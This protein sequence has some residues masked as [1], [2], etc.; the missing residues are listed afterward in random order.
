MTA[1]QI[2]AI[3]I[4]LSPQCRTVIAHMEKAG[5][6]SYRDAFTD[7]DMTSATLASRIS[8]IDKAGIPIK[9]ESK[10]NPATGKRYTRYSIKHTS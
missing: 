9:R 10:I 2:M 5:S 7:L 4:N 1:H 8:Q 3:A 6:I